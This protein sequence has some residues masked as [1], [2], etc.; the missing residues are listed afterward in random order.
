MMCHTGSKKKKKSVSP[1]EC[2]FQALSN[3]QWEGKGG[4]ELLQPHAKS[5]KGWI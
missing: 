3:L 1:Q 2:A 5:L 4:K